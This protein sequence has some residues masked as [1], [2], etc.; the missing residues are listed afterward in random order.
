MG[1]FGASLRISDLFAN[2]LGFQTLSQ[3]GVQD[4]LSDAGTVDY[5]GPSPVAGCEAYLN[6]LPPHAASSVAFVKENLAVV[7][8]KWDHGGVGECRL[9]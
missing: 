7:P 2:L 8:D 4:P 6:A 1:T 5:A 3:F 9:H